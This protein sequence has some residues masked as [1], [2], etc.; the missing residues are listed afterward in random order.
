MV[1]K[2]FFYCLI[3]IEMLSAGTGMDLSGIKVQNPKAIN[4]ITIDKH[5]IMPQIVI[6]V[7]MKN[8]HYFNNT[9]YVTVINKNSFS[10]KY[11]PVFK[12]YYTD[13][14]KKTMD[15]CDTFL[16]KNPGMICL[17]LCV[18]GNLGT[19]TIKGKKITVP[20]K[21]SKEFRIYNLPEHNYKGAEIIIGNV[22]AKCKVDNMKQVN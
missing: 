22:K 2:T 15:Y 11:N 5:K 17:P 18:D 16:K 12:G 10:Q 8:A 6:P 14:T 13:C 21:G 1:R 19:V 20:A 7:V 4:E 3:G 9:V